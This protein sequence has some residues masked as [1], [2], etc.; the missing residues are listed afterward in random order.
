[1]SELYLFDRVASVEF[2][3]E[4]SLGTRIEDLRISFHIKKVSTPEGN[5]A[6]ITI[7]N[8]S[9]NTRSKVKIDQ[10]VVLRA[11]YREAFGEED[12]FAG[13]IH[14]VNNLI[15]TPNI[16]TIIESK[17]GSKKLED[18]KVSLSYSSGVSVRDILK[19]ITSK[20]G[21]P[22]KI[23]L[24][25]IN[26][27][28]FSF[29]QGVSFVGEIKHLLNYLCSS[30]NLE[31]S[32]QGNKL[33]IQNKRESDLTE[34][35]VISPDTGLIGSPER[36]LDI[37]GNRGK[38]KKKEE[39]IPGWKIKCLLSPKIEP[40]GAVQV[41]SREIPQGSTFKVYEVEHI[42]DTHGA[43]WVSNIKVQE[44]ASS[45]AKPEYNIN[46]NDDT[47]VAFV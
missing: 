14:N 30:A 21:I 9:E 20:T 40:G 44:L 32:F 23:D 5:D 34:A 39:P 6:K 43:D 2:G 33:K 28:N 25:L 22:L 45:V 17:D 19:D 37:E 46:F 35:V 27:D 24:D 10:V 13:Y 47:E 42:G 11:G 29:S 3:P 41:Y 26:M 15:E 7:S 31:W 1:M 38:K 36:V 16:H 18:A 4:G 8:L 12:L